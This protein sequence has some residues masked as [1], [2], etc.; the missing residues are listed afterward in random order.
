MLEHLMHVGAL[1][2]ATTHYSE[3]KVF[4]HTQKR[5]ENAC[6]EFD[7]QSLRPTFKLTVGI[8]GESNAFEIAG[9]LGLRQDLIE[10]ARILLRPEH[11][12]LADLIQN[13][14][15]DQVVAT[16]ARAEA[17]QLKS[18]VERLRAQL[19]GE[20]DKIRV[21]EKEIMSRATSEARELVRTARRE[22]ETLIR[23]L[24]EEQKQCDLQQK[25]GKAQDARSKLKVIADRIEKNDDTVAASPVQ[26]ETGVFHKGDRV[27]IPRYNQD[28]YLL[29]DPNT[30][31]E[32]LVQ[33]GILKLSLSVS[34][35]RRS[36]NQ[37][38]SQTTFTRSSVSTIERDAS[39]SPELDFRGLRVDDAIEAVDKYLDTAYL[40]GLTKVSLI[41]G[42]GTGVLRDVVRKYLATHP[43][44]AS[45]RS[46][47]Y[48]EG[49]T[50]I[51]VVQ[52]K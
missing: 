27:T 5:A 17:E 9:R 45:Y 21:K 47:D 14:K 50:G 43:M 46:G 42:K 38:Q 48:D 15:E 3:L 39:V 49:G 29:Q 13:L 20:Q 52:F 36:L 32:V 22:A 41:H 10:R 40:A 19:Q 51:T 12:E 34:E 2:M 25:I 33:V 35:L 28:G 18:E 23:S 11:R 31:G 24:R 26:G 44:V 30:S 16:A 6:V 7:R 37:E 8:P 4:A 1:T